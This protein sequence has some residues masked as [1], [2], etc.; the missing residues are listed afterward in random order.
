MLLRAWRVCCRLTG[1]Q[2][3]RSAFPER[4]RATPAQGEEE[5]PRSPGGWSAGAR[6]RRGGA[7]PSSE[8]FFPKPPRL[9][10]L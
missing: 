7:G 8:T 6:A 5:D 2:G 1:T 4:V 9:C 10:G 3:P